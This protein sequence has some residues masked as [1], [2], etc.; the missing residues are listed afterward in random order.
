MSAEV[1]DVPTVTTGRGA[2]LW[3][4]VGV[5]TTLWGFISVLAGPG[6]PVVGEAFEV[7]PIF[8]VVGPV[9]LGA[10]IARLRV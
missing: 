8:A 1:Q 4:G 7:L 3:T 9:I 6:V 5:T 10:G 2:L